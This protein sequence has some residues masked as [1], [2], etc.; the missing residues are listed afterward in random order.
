MGRANGIPS[1]SPDARSLLE[2][3]LQLEPTQALQ[4]DVRHP[5]SADALELIR[6][7][8]AETR[9]EILGPALWRTPKAEAERLDEI[10][11]LGT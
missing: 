2:T 7:G 1:L 10:R 5:L 11:R 4:Y 3:L 9:P 8:Y 6:A